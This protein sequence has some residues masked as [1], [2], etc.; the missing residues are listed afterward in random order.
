MS[1]RKY[2][3]RR[4]RLPEL[5][6]DYLAHNVLPFEV[7]P[8]SGLATKHKL[9]SDLKDDEGNLIGIVARPKA[10]SRDYSND[11]YYGCLLERHPGKPDDLFVASEWTSD[12]D[13]ET[14]NNTDAEGNINTDP[15]RLICLAFN[16]Y[17]PEEKERVERKLQQQ[18]L[19]VQQTVWFLP[20][21]LI[22]WLMKKPED[23]KQGVAQ[24]G[25]YY[26]LD[27]KLEGKDLVLDENVMPGKI[28]SFLSRYYELKTTDGDVVAKIYRRPG[29]FGLSATHI[30]DE[31]GM[32]I[33]KKY[34]NNKTL[35]YL[36]IALADYL[37]MENK[38]R[39]NCFYEGKESEGLP[40]L[41]KLFR[42]D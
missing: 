10:Y 40:N 24:A 32:D 5:H 41:S 8:W 1:F 7:Q 14:T 31:Y 35:L 12:F 34:E 22:K 33:D 39:R 13:Q 30:V 20:I 27:F 16:L 19:G 42:Y 38:I 36:V 2:T 17:R 23:P 9:I 29:F 4:R 6:W 15:N 28:K 37:H 21:N 3:L 26:S 18:R 11:L 25:S